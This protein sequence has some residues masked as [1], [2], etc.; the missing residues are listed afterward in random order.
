MTKLQAKFL[1]PIM[2]VSGD[3]RP[4]WVKIPIEIGHY[5]MDQTHS[6]THDPPGRWASAWPWVTAPYKMDE[7]G[8]ELEEP[9]DWARIPFEMPQEEEPFEGHHQFTPGVEGACIASGFARN[10]RAHDGSSPKEKQCATLRLFI[11]GRQLWGDPKE[12]E[13]LPLITETL[14]YRYFEIFA[15]S[16]IDF[17]ACELPGNQHWGMA[18]T[19][20]EMEEGGQSGS[21]QKDF[22]LALGTALLEE[23]NT[24]ARLIVERG[25]YLEPDS[26]YD[27]HPYDE[28]LFGRLE[29]LGVAKETIQKSRARAKERWTGGPDVLGS[30]L[31]WMEPMPMHYDDGPARVFAPWAAML[32]RALWPRVKAQV[33]REQQA[34][35]M[36]P[37]LSRKLFET[38]QVV[39]AP[40]NELMKS[41]DQFVICSPEKR[42]YH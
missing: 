36:V 7:S 38:L 16:V 18:E 42:S 34:K 1:V 29:E 32:A 8:R 35:N 10:K 25:V 2:A 11:Q 27:L 14:T 39:S 24:L 15:F 28:V 23:A 22:T 30:W 13:Q 6:F 40:R 20:I 4:R 3:D 17:Y 12:L 26:P 33:E 9:E 19:I 5:G 21:M 37:A 31:L 41:G